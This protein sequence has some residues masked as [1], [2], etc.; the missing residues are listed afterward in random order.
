MARQPQAL[1]SH[2]WNGEGHLK[3]ACGARPL[4]VDI[5]MHPLSVTCKSCLAL[6]IKSAK[7]RTEKLEIDLADA[8]GFQLDLQRH[9]NYTQKGKVTCPIQ[10]RCRISSG[11]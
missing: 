2:W 7:Q 4:V 11:I 10:S 1:K 6:A 3:T 8:L 9:L 5:K